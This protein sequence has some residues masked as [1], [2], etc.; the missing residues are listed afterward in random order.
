MGDKCALHRVV[1]VGERDCRW[2][3]GPYGRASIGKDWNKPPATPGCP[4]MHSLWRFAALTSVVS[5]LAAVQRERVD[6]PSLFTNIA[7]AA[8]VVGMVI[9]VGIN[10]NYRRIARSF[11]GGTNRHRIHVLTVGDIA[12]IMLA[13]QFWV[14]GLALS[15]M[16]LVIFTHNIHKAH[17]HVLA[18]GPPPPK[19]KKPKEQ[20]EAKDILERLNA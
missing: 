13:L 1:H 2:V 18:F 14:A 16:T 6:D 7:V 17:A 15:L 10:L 3:H 12:V 20:L 9:I 5:V 11:F 19:V 8:F 4:Y